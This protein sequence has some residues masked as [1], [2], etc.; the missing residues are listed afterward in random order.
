MS[1]AS[2][3]ASIVRASYF[4]KLLLSVT[5]GR[6]ERVD[7]GNPQLTEGV[8]KKTGAE[9]VVDA[10]IREKVDVVF[11]YPGGVVLPL[12]DAFW[13]VDKLKVILT[14]HEQA[15][16]HAADGY[17]RA[18]GRVGVCVATS[19][20]GAT[21]LVTGIATAYLDSVP[22]V[23]I[24]GQVATPILGT[25][26]FQEA[27]IVGITRPITKHN[28]LV[29]DVAEL[30]TMLKQ[31]FHIAATGRPGPVLVDIPKDVSTG[32][33]DNYEYPNRVD[34]RS[35]KPNVV[36][37][38]RQIR[39]AAE[40]IAAAEKPLIYAGGGIIISGAHREL[41][42]LA[43]KTNIPVTTTLMGLGGF[44]GDHP[45]FVGMPCRKPI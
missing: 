22:I 25:D 24:T 45:L 30:P 6:L 10:L 20:P 42:E 43:E 9:I 4:T 34:I 8:V 23:A 40:A 36:G 5:A 11:G 12:F 15:A 35:Y 3:L 41:L 26:A 31:A 18:T 38:I 19:G 39:K 37:H 32:V 21:N 16:A 17:A 1:G 33:L 28:F 14:R 7:A 29:K 2:A 13:G 44:P 27:D